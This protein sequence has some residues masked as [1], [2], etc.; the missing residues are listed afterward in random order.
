[1][2]GEIQ[3]FL[4][5]YWMK[6]RRDADQEFFDNL[7]A[8]HSCDRL[9]SEEVFDRIIGFLAP[10]Q[11]DLMRLVYREGLDPAEAGRKM[12]LSKYRGCYIHT[13]CIR[14]IYLKM[15]G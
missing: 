13:E 5:S 7:E 12:G 14:L 2:K 10:R 9:E 3:E 11:R 8:R 1:M 6:H 15:T 4:R